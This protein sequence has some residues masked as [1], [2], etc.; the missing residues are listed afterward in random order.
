[1]DGSPA[2][3]SA[4]MHEHAQLRQERWSETL[5]N[6]L[7]NRKDIAGTQDVHFFA[8]PACYF[9]VCKANIHFQSRYLQTAVYKTD[10]LCYDVDS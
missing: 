9:H 8:Y 2:L 5:G 7:Y 10:V 6:V 3:R 4:E 1:M